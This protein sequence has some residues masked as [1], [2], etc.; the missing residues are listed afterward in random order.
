MR[1]DTDYAG[2]SGPTVRVSKLCVL[3][4]YFVCVYVCMRHDVDAPS[5]CFSKAGGREGE[6][7]G[8]EDLVGVH[9]WCRIT[10]VYTRRR[11]HPR[12]RGILLH[13]F[14]EGPTIQKGGLTPPPPS[15]LPVVS[16]IFCTQT[17]LAEVLRHLGEEGETAGAPF[18]GRPHG[19]G[20][21]GASG[22]LCCVPCCL[23]SWVQCI[24]IRYRYFP[25]RRKRTHQ[26]WL[27]IKGTKPV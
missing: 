22:N 13:I 4:V 27:R 12:G 3:Y 2:D 9:D 19:E 26:S 11:K 20:V 21:S 10:A 1:Y 15:F 6:R 5:C 17:V 16:S 24:Y 7:G 25:N 23:P 14:V 18:F 8:S